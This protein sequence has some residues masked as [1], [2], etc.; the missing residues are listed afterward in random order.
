MEL[1]EARG[2]LI[3]IGGGDITEGDAPLRKP[4]GRGAQARFKGKK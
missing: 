1:S 3:A 4:A 2:R